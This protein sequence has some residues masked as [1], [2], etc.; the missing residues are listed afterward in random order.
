MRVVLVDGVLLD[1]SGV[2]ERAK[3]QKIVNAGTLAYHVFVS[4][5]KSALSQR[6]NKHSH[7]LPDLIS[8]VALPPLLVGAPHL[9]SGDK[10]E[11]PGSE[12]SKKSLVIVSVVSAKSEGR[13]WI[14][15]HA[16]RT[17]ERAGERKCL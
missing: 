6:G 4:V 17:Q 12:E 15:L 9:L 2:I 8:S 10:I 14:S 3:G 16:S 11:L 1:T 13:D 5:D 7:S